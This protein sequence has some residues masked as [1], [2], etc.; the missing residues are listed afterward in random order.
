MAAFPG[1]VPDHNAAAL[2]PPHVNH[3]DD[4]A[5]GR[6]QS[7]HGTGRGEA[8]RCCMACRE[9]RSPQ[10]MKTDPGENQPNLVGTPPFYRHTPHLAAAL[11]STCPVVPTVPKAE[12]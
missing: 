2:N 6:Q 5:K 9:R 8:P 1:M 10:T 7:Q 3:S 11:N 4:I 12:R